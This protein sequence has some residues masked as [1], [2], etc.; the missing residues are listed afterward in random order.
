M[1]CVE[2][3]VPRWEAG[4]GDELRCVYA[5]VLSRSR[6]RSEKGLSDRST[7]WRMSAPA[8]PVRRGEVGRLG[9]GVSGRFMPGWSIHGEGERRFGERDGG[10][11][12]VRD[13]E[14]EGER[15]RMVFVWGRG[16][17][18]EWMLV[19]L[20]RCNADGREGRGGPIVVVEGCGGSR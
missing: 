2:D 18:A 6:F 13:G 14:E 9:R 5:G 19:L 12:R 4:D 3:E 15:R 10:R 17:S 20:L 7:L 8:R 1:C 11:C 16:R